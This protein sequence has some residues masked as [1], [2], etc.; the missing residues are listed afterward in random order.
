[1]MSSSRFSRNLDSDRRE[2]GSNPPIK[3]KV[4]TFEELE[5]H[6]LSVSGQKAKQNIPSRS[7]CTPLKKTEGSNSAAKSS[8]PATILMRSNSPLRQRIRQSILKHDE[9]STPELSPRALEDSKVSSVFHYDNSDSS[10]E[11]ESR[12]S[13][14]VTSPQQQQQPRRTFLEQRVHEMRVAKLAEARLSPREAVVTPVMNVQNSSSSTKFFTPSPGHNSITTTNKTTTAS[15]QQKSGQGLAGPMSSRAFS[16]VKERRKAAAN[17]RTPP[18]PHSASSMTTA[19]RNRASRNL[20]Q[21][22]LTNTPKT[23]ATATKTNSRPSNQTPSTP[24][25]SSTTT[26]P[27]RSNNNYED[28]GPST[29]RNL[30]KKTVRLMYSKDFANQIDRY[31]LESIY[32][33]AVSPTISKNIHDDTLQLF[34]RKRPIFAKQVEQGDFDVV[35]ILDRDAFDTDHSKTTAATA[36]VVYKTT[37]NSDMKTKVVQPFVFSGC[38]RAAFS[39]QATSEQVYQTAVRPLV[40]SVLQ[41]GSKAATLLMFGQ[42]RRYAALCR[43]EDVDDI[44]NSFMWWFT[45]YWMHVFFFFN[46]HPKTGSG[47]TYTMNACQK[48][49]AAEIFADRSVEEVQVQCLEL[50]GKKCYDLSQ[51]GSCYKQSIVEIRDNPDGSVDFV[52]AATTYA[53]YPREILSS[54]VAAQKNRTTHSTEV[55]DVSSRSHAVY[56][57]RILRTNQPTSVLTLLDCAGTERRHDSLFHSQERQSE[58]TEINASL[59]ALKE[60]IRIRSQNAKSK[61]HVHVPYRSSNLTRILRESLECADARLHVIATVSPN[62]TDTEHTIHTLKTIST[63]TGSS[64]QERD[65]YQWVSTWRDMSGTSSPQL[66]APKKMSHVELVQWLAERNLLGKS[67]VPEHIDGKGVMKMSKIQ[68]K[69]LLYD[70]ADS[71]SGDEKAELLFK[72]LRSETEQVAQDEHK[73]RMQHVDRQ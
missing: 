9:Y 15:F 47:K 51:S 31:R 62:A 49:V 2:G 21:Q 27:P 44:S 59:Y 52:N 25:A 71:R 1:M 46:L 60:C 68:L 6:R 64:W 18:L 36:V 54:L 53:R 57:L 19:A 34:V 55:N 20:K 56:Q 39:A 69:Y 50:I 30:D 37:M 7:S 72:I 35:E 4:L 10:P 28:T 67:R 61:K 58:S 63:L 22:Q 70:D 42:V 29:R 8:T 66:K 32:A 13:K 24:A 33:A 41:R 17:T 16:L 12:D 14:E 38:I 26:M 11:L 40:Q 5:R 43:Q 65:S 48:L 23:P 3:K 45:S 73:R